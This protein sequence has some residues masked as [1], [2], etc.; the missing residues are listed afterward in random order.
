MVMF[1]AVPVGFYPGSVKGVMVCVC[2]CSF[3]SLRGGATVH[4]SQVPDVHPAHMYS[5][6]LSIRLLG[7]ERLCVTL[8]LYPDRWMDVGA[9]NRPT[10][11]V[12]LPFHKT[13]SLSCSV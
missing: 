1:I 7:K 11:L 5:V 4:H 9:G 2:V 8:I 10:S 6:L 12:T 13:Y 3:V